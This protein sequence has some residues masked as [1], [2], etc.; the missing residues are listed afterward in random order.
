MSKGTDTLKG[1]TLHSNQ[2]L[3]GMQKEGSA[4]LGN[5]SDQG[6]LSFVLTWVRMC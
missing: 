1:H 3:L 5:V 6:T 4:V 2:N